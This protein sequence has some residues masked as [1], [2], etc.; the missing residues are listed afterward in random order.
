MKYKV[1]KVSDNMYSL[2]VDAKSEEEAEEI[3]EKQIESSDWILCS[4]KQ[5]NEILKEYTELLDET[6]LSDDN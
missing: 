1:Y 3:A 5:Q 2:T 6:E 4:G